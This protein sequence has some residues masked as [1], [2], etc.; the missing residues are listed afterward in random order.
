MD[1]SADKLMGRWHDF[2]EQPIEVIE[3]EFT[4]SSRMLL[5]RVLREALGYAEAGK[6]PSAAEFAKYV[7]ELRENERNWSRRLGDVILQA[8]GQLEG[9]D[10]VAAKKT[11]EEFETTCPWRFFVDIA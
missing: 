3:R 7:V 2:A 6:F 11:F 5:G 4:R 8:Q 1:K 10:I 9:G